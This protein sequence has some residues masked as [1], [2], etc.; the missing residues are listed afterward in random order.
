MYFQLVG[1]LALGLAGR[2]SEYFA[3]KKYKARSTSVK[4]GYMW[5]GQCI[6]NQGL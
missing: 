4:A 5:A 2:G 6:L 1:A 3:N